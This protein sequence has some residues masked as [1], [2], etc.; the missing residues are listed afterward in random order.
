MK[1]GDINRILELLPHRYPFL[2]V[3]RMVE[4]EK[5]KSMTALKN[6]T[7]NEPFFQ[8]HFPNQKVMP[9][10]LI[11]E[12]L[13]QVTGLLA[14]ESNPNVAGSDA[15]YMLVGIDKARFKHPVFPGDQLILS[16]ELKAQKRGI[17][18]F[19]CKAVV[20][21]KLVASAEMLCTAREL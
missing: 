8:G 1:N 11:V 21:D 12:A 17:I 10:V 7:Y 6:V 5:D 20:D 3:D 2:L 14:L 4:F 18:R 19:A 13:A 15:I 16:V 9:G